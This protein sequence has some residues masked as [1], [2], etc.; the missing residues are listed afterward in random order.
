MRALLLAGLFALGCSKKEEEPPRPPPPDQRPYEVPSPDPPRLPDEDVVIA[1]GDLD[2][3]DVQ[4]DGMSTWPPEGPGCQQLIR[5]C[6]A[7]RHLP[8]MELSCRLSIA[9]D[10]SC[11]DALTTV[12]N[13]LTESGHEAPASCTPE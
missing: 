6:D 11:A 4:V 7:I 5:C 3:I 12:R 1:P 10:R 9:A 2:G 13:I 8:A